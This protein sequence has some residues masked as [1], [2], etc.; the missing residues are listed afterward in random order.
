MIDFELSEEQQMIRD[1]VGAFAREKIRPAAR[2][3]DESGA[4]PA[5]LVAEAWQF[6]FV[7]G[8]IPEKFGGGGDTRSAVTGAIV[9]EELGFGDI[10][11]ALHV[12]APRLFAFPIVEMGT[13]DQRAKYLKRFTGADFVAATAA[14]MEPRFDFDLSALA[15]FRQARRRRI[16]PERRQMLRAARGRIGFDAGICG[17]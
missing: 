8:A 9:A 13:D 3:A 7:S 12:L 2:P 5:A 14:V 10:S 15:G 6:G 4:I 11:I 17:D 1:S 16:R